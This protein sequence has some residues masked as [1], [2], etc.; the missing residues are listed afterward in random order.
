MI[1]ND[2]LKWRRWSVWTKPEDADD[3]D[4]EPAGTV[5]DCTAEDGKFIFKTPSQELTGYPIEGSRVWF[6]TGDGRKIKMFPPSS[7]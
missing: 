4:C 6:T 7:V 3:H 2:G 5:I 1:W